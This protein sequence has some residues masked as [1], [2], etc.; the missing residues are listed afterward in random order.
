LGRQR[1]CARE[2]YDECGACFRAASM[3]KGTGL[4][5]PRDYR[6]WISNSGTL[7]AKISKYATTSLCC[8]QAFAMLLYR[9]NALD[10]SLPRTRVPHISRSSRD[11][12]SSQTL[13]VCNLRAP[14]R[15]PRSGGKQPWNFPHLAKNARCSDFLYAIP[16]SA[17]CAA[18][19]EG[20]PHERRRVHKASQEIRGYGAPEF[21][22]GK[23]PEI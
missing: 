18:F 20:K 3:S 19:S 14:S 11:V 22:A 12:G 16:S 6:V 13:T 10:F 15:F 4:P 2:T 17:A 9:T 5:K 23:I 1:T 7:Q 21:V 8:H